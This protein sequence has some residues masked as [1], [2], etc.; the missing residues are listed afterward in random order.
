M[1]RRHWLKRSALVTAG[2]P[3]MRV[4]RPRTIGTSPEAIEGA[5]WLDENENPFGISAKADRAIIQST[6]IS[7]RY[8]EDDGPELRKL[9]AGR[10]GIPE[11]HIL[12]GAGSTEIL[13]LAVILY[14]R[15]GKQVLMA[16][17][18]YFDFR[19]YAVRLK[20]KL[21]SVPLN[22]HYAHDLPGF[23]SRMS[24]N[25]SLVYICNPN[26][27]TG[28]IADGSALRDFCEAASRRSIVLVDEA[29]HELVEDPRHASMLDL[30]KKGRN[31]IVTR[32]FSKIYGLAGL[33]IGY[34]LAGPELIDNLRRVQTNF[35]PVSALSLAAATASYTDAEYVQSCRQKFAQAK[36]FFCAELGK[37]QYSFV[38]SQTNFVI[39]QVKVKAKE[40][41]DRLKEKKIYVRPFEFFDRNWI[42]ASIGTMQEMQTLADAL[43]SLA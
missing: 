42:R 18:G 12:I 22:D 5:V 2:L 36:A 40:L 15:D 1:D 41:S 16:D 30:V 32:T 38:P 25:T 21:V 17:P 39:F 27:P 28:T 9:I 31:V 8:P 29:Y 20:A 37:M 33:R 10:E 24:R 34:G 43:R 3:L 13:S 14:G 19:N 11:N 23:E 6:S 35:A 4:P 26:N 7:N